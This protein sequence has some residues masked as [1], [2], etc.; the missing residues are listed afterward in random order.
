MIPSKPTPIQAIVLRELATNKN[1]RIFAKMH[2][3]RIY[4]IS[5][6]KWTKDMPVLP[7]A[8]VAALIRAGWIETVDVDR[9]MYDI[10][11]N[12][13]AA[14][15]NLEPGDFERKRCEYSANDILQV[16]KQRHPS[17]DWVYFEEL[18]G[19][20]GYLVDQRIDA[21]AMHTW[22]SKGFLSIAY[23]VKISRSDLLK[24]LHQPTKHLFAMNVSN[25]FYYAVPQ[26][27]MKKEE[28]PECCGLIEIAD[29][30]A[31][32]VV[33]AENR[34]IER[35]PWFFVSALARRLEP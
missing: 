27:L 14:L 12:G 22:P 34:K 16:I 33:K 21:W 15:A 5:W 2:R 28:L 24:E 9:G 17:P 25:E 18:R 6:F 1:V 35:P 3:D 8:T 26:G 20:T 10:T 30:D 31:K 7:K 32:V 29:D 13:L 4:S 23:E 11:D 19:S